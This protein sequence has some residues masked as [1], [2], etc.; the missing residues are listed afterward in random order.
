E[1][2]QKDRFLILK[3]PFDNIEVQ[4]LAEALTARYIAEQALRE[5]DR[6]LRE[7][8]QI[9]RIGHYISDGR[10][11]Q[12]TRSETIDE[13]FGF[14]RQQEHD[15]DDYL[16]L[17]DPQDR[18][19]IKDKVYG[20][21][22]TDSSF[23]QV[24]RVGRQSDGAGRWISA[25][26]RWERDANGRL[27]RLI[28]TFQDVT[29]GFE[30]QLMLR[31]LQTSVEHINDAVLITDAAVV[32]QSGP[33]LLFVNDAFVRLTG[34]ERAEVLGR[35]PKF[36]QGENTQ[37]SELLRIR[38]ALAQ[39]RPVKVELI[40]YAK[41]GREF[42]VGLDIVPVHNAQ[43]LCINWVCVMRDVT[44]QRQA[45]AEIERLA[46]HDSL[47]GLANRL[48]LT[49]RLHQ[50]LAACARHPVYCGLMFIDLDNFKEIND[51]FGH[52]RGDLMLVELARRLLTCVR[53][54]DTVARFGGDEF[55]VLLKS[56]GNNAAEAAANAEIVYRKIA[57][58]MAEIFFL[59]GSEYRTNASVG[60]SL[61]GHEPT[62]PDELLRHVDIAMYQAK[63]AGK[64]TFRFFDAAMQQMVDERAWLGNELRRAQERDQL[65]LH[66]QPQFD[67]RRGLFGAEVLL[68]WAYPG[69]GMVSPAVFIP[70]AEQTGLIRDMGDWVIEMACRQ[71]VAWTNDPVLDRLT[72]SVNVSSHQFQ[73]SD[74]VDSV[75]DAVSRTG[76]R[77]QR[78]KLELTESTLIHDLTDISQ[79]MAA[80]KA[81]GIG[82]ALDD[83]GTGYSSLSYLKRLS[84]DQ[85]KIDQSFVRDV[86]TDPN[87]A[88]IART[89]VALGQSLGLEVVAEGV[90]TLEQKDFLTGIG[91]HAFQGY[92]FS[93][94][95]PIRDFE[96]FVAQWVRDNPGL[97][98]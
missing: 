72:L 49:D 47:T 51:T 24:C 33:R 10:T 60:I 77:P 94:P 69:R 81:R 50:T 16:N 12:W 39:S 78:L 68:R 18:L 31:L 3:K 43:G 6:I 66:F 46:Y 82:V 64:N 56:L 14:D 67:T 98:D 21:T 70:L 53:E 73:M 65:S 37:R 38:E 23:D 13:M 55:V 62:S 76:A 71:L 85:L 59:H 22:P 42:W 93:R 17:M 29:D 83:F 4:Q 2:P 20:A 52:E 96:R 63:T 11:G 5:K 54:E 26:G 7:A 8:Q 79:K 80:L 36:L 90:E 15:L 74:F 57:Q 1:L 41:T 44:A 9:A 25:R 48:L 35:S 89:I 58:V 91:C 87:D 86:L 45:N 92:Y 19:S 28:G 30:S 61:F 34:Y 32:E 97:G 95:V 27:T 88:A 75:L 40:N 84:L